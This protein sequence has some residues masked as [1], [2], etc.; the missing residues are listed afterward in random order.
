VLIGAHSIAGTPEIAKTI[1]V[2]FGVASTYAIIYNVLMW[3]KEHS[4]D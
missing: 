4:H 2:P 3:K 1:A